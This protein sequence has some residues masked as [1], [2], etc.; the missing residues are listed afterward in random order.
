[1]LEPGCVWGEVLKTRSILVA[2]TLVLLLLV[3]GIYLLLRPQPSGDT[4]ATLPRRAEKAAPRRLEAPSAALHFYLALKVERAL[5]LPLVRWKARGLRGV[6]ISPGTRPSPHAEA[7]QERLRLALRGQGLELLLD[8]RH[9]EQL[10]PSRWPQVAGVLL[11]H[12][13]AIA[14]SSKVL[15]RAGLR[16]AVQGGALPELQRAK[17]IV[18]G[19]PECF[20]YAAGCWVEGGRTRGLHSTLAELVSTGA[21]T[22][23]WQLEEVAALEPVVRMLNRASELQRGGATRPLLG[24]VADRRLLWKSEF[25]S[26]LA[27]ASS[28]AGYRL[29]LVEAGEGRPA[30][31]A[32]LFEGSDTAAPARIAKLLAR[33][34]P[35]VLAIS[36]L[37]PSPLWQSTLVAAGLDPRYK[38]SPLAPGPLRTSRFGGQQLRWNA[39]GDQPRDTVLLDPADVQGEV[40]AGAE[41]GGKRVALAVRQGRVLLLNGVRLHR[42]ARFIVQR[43]LGGALVK[44]FDGWGMVAKEA[45]FVASRRSALAANLPLAEGSKIRVTRV[46]AA[47][48]DATVEV[49]SYRAPLRATLDAG[50]LLLV[51]PID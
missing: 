27:R 39:D 20:R 2:G 16:L 13:Q 21:R 26:L 28:L 36:H 25:L 12:Q 14:P 4:S 29:A 41:V 46:D 11:R 15:D 9:L 34:G 48:G 23:V 45:A 5:A 40:V 49:W 18:L 37:A 24:V 19:G 33:D 42:E 43:L 8:V 50:E 47:G 6:V 10:E 7:Q 3:A 51:E 31:H 22:V 32:A 35:L 17:G 1:M 30:A 38:G 44:P